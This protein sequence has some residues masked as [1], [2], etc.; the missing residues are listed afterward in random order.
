MSP[1]Q[2]YQRGRLTEA[3]A[4]WSAQLAAGRSWTDIEAEIMDCC[5]G[6]V[7]L[8]TGL[9]LEAEVALACARARGMTGRAAGTC[10]ERHAAVMSRHGHW[11]SPDRAPVDVGGIGP[12]Y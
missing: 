9:L 7:D 8:L 2:E 11:S 12:W 1:T 6:R 10:P 4:R 3:L 5:Q